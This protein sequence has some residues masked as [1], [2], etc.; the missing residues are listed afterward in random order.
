MLKVRLSRQLE[1]SK[2]IFGTDKLIRIWSSKSKHELLHTAIDLGI[3]HFDT[4]P[5][6]GFGYAEIDLRKILKAHP[7]LTVTSKLGLYPPGRPNKQF[8]DIMFRKIGGRFFPNFKKP[9]VDF[10]TE[11]ARI[12]LEASLKRLGRDYLDLVLVHDP[13]WSEMDCDTWVYFFEQA[14]K[15]GL[16]KQFGVDG[17]VLRINE[18]MRNKPELCPII[19][20][21]DNLQYSSADFCK[22][23]NGEP[24]I[25][26]GYLADALL[27]GANKDPLEA[28]SRGLSRFKN[29][30]VIASTTNKNHLQD[31]VNTVA[32]LNFG[33]VRS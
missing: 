32:R 9:N 12:F 3:T 16:I 19:Q 4:A 20:C 22:R 6:Y 25:T 26:Y 11:K 14:Q 17:A 18:V 13:V 28:F 8:A 29:S 30:A 27:P 5:L 7:D 31:L 1:V 24:N 10:T 23:L 2:L 33:E 15:E 21:R